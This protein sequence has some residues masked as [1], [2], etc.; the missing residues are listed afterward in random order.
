MQA[1]AASSA[2]APANSAMTVEDASNLASNQD[3]ASDQAP[4]A[5]TVGSNA[6]T[7]ASSAAGAVS[8]A[9]ASAKPQQGGKPRFSADEDEEMDS[10]VEEE[11]EGK[12]AKHRFAVVFGYVG[13]NYQGLQKNPGAHTIEDEL[14]TAI[15]KAGLI[16]PENH[17]QL[18]K[19]GWN[20]A[21]RTDKGVHA[22][23]QVVSLRMR[24]KKGEADATRERINS[25]L[26][27]DIRVV[28]IVRVT[29]Q[30]NSKNLCSGRR[31]GYILPTFTLAP[32]PPIA[33]VAKAPPM[34][35][36]MKQA[37]KKAQ[38]AGSNSV[39]LAQD[40]FCN[41]TAFALG[42]QQIWDAA[43]ASSSA[44]SAAAA[45]AG[46]ESSSA[47]AG[48]GT[49]TRSDGSY[50]ARGIAG[51]V[52][53]ASHATAASASSPSSSAP[54]ADDYQTG[55]AMVAAAQVTWASMSAAAEAGRTQ[56]F[57]CTEAQLASLREMLAKYKG[58][59]AFH[60]FSPRISSG[61]ATAMRYIVD[62][63]ASKPFL[64]GSGP[65]ALEYTHITIVGQSFLLNQIRHM[66]GLAVDVVR[67]AAP[68]FAIDLAFSS[69]GIKLPIAPAEG[70]YLD[71]VG[72]R[73]WLV[74]DVCAP[75]C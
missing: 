41:G 26:P 74:G 66:V 44:S 32:R 31:Y 14:E 40:P 20:R 7:S 38:Q 61:D 42:R 3:T 6:T 51:A 28:D 71:Q 43:A 70:L 54:D 62:C 46:A 35:E 13:A 34:S 27:A 33:Y 56:G 10:D 68:P 58:T 47:P 65:T 52:P 23:G 22:A 2:A 4:T 72:A 5:A 8:A 69:G 18:A 59:H 75:R 12:A 60:N 19:V 1:P 21:A 63:T 53:L 11:G 64:V 17:G 9:S 25:F 24:V 49:D 67:G 16:E 37:V 39:A 48:S 57:R 36:A 30:F 29:R 15:F 73:R 55:A 50:F 45:G